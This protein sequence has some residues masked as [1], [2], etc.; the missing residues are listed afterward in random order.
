[1]EQVTN[2]LAAWCGAKVEELYEFAYSNIV[3]FHG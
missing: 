2:L 1:M 3:R